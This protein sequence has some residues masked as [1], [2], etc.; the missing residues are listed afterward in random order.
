MARFAWPLLLA[1]LLLGGCGGGVD[2]G[3]PRREVPGVTGS[4]SPINEAGEQASAEE[5]D[6]HGWRALRLTN[7]MVT[8]VAVPDIGGRIMEYKLGG[9]PYLWTN[10]SELGKTYPQPRTE[11][12]RA[13]HNFG[14]Y[15]LWP[16]PPERWKGPPDPLGSQIDG[17][18]W[19]GKILTA[20]GRNAEIEISSPEDKVTGLQI[21]RSIKL[22]GSSSQVRVTE[23]ITNISKDNADWAFVRVSSLPGSLE[24]G[25]KYSDKSRL[26]IPVNAQGKYK[27]GYV[28]L[29]AGGGAQYKLLPE[30][31]LQ[32]S[33]Q[34]QKGRIGVDSMAGWVAHVDAQH[35]YGLIQRSAPTNLG[36][37]PEQGASVIVDTAADQSMMTLGLYSPSRTLRPGE[38]YEI[39]TDWYAARVGGPIL[40][41]TEVAAIQQPLKLERAEGKTKVTGTI[42]VFVPGS[43]AFILQDESGVAIGQ[44]TLVKASPA[45]VVKLSQV[46]PEEKTAKS[47]LIELQND[48]G[49]P[50]GKIATL[51]LG[52]TLADKPA[53]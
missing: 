47:V 6:Y 51:P 32:V 9:H 21:T 42:G 38:S 26:Y 52:V 1:L 34:G 43:L 39:V 12:D 49:T 7:G 30:G 48:S 11:Q 25:A 15:T 20:S 8:L 45:A 23:K 13:W 27:D 28:T 35:D 46:L 2:S 31:V 44:P 33:Y 16:A 37:Y 3:G 14:G 4:S 22:F 36:E 50:L 5:I 10:P 17:G 19:T 40:D 41:T 53:K 24:D 18:K 29:A